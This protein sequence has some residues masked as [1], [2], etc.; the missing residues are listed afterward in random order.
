MGEPRLPKQLEDDVRNCAEDFYQ[1][2]RWARQF[3][4]HA[5]GIGTEEKLDD[6]DTSK[7]FLVMSRFDSFRKKYAAHEFDDKET[8][9]AVYM[10][11]SFNKD[12]MKGAIQDSESIIERARAD[13]THQ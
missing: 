5:K 11:V 1:D 4:F 3:L 12:E 9:Y 8:L 10:M 2:H 6:D 13:E 7:M